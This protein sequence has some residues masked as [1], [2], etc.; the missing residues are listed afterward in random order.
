M[1]AKILA[2]GAIMLSPVRRRKATTKNIMKRNNVSIVSL[3][4]FRLTK[5]QLEGTVNNDNTN[6]NAGTQSKWKWNRSRGAR[7]AS[8]VKA[9]AYTAE[10]FLFSWTARFQAFFFSLR[11]DVTTT[12]IFSTANKIPLICCLLSSRGLHS[13]ISSVLMWKIL[14]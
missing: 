14:I 3:F 5:K 10:H 4:F 11:G 1:C 2:L 12:L 7:S 13:M 8:R 9:T 6:E